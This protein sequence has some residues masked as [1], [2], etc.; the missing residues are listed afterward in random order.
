M[1]PTGQKFV[2]LDNI[3]EWT[4]AMLT[5]GTIYTEP[6]RKFLLIPTERNASQKK[7]FCSHFMS[8]KVFAWG[9]K[10]QRCANPAPC[11]FKHGCFQCGAKH[12]SH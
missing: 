4:S 6:V 7:T 2:A 8:H 10:K 3:D 9:I 1:S 11:H 12:A 5:L